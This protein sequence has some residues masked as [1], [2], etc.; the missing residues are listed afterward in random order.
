MMDKLTSSEN[1]KTFV[2]ENLK[3]DLRVYERQLNEINAETVE[4]V[5]LKHMIE[6][7]LLNQKNGEGFKTQVNIGGNMFMKA[8][9][10][11]ASRLLVDIGLKV[12]VEFTIDE[13]LRFVE[14]RIKVLTKQAD[15][16]RDKSIETKTNIKL[17]LLVIG[18]GQRLHNVEEQR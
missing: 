11:N 5:H 10:D 16:I 3:E 1:I 4:Y 2:H 15:V 7:I 18:E 14:M 13:A 17:A 6:T 12:Y 9:A 8:R